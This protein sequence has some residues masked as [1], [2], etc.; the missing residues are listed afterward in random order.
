[1]QTI[2]SIFCPFLTYG[3]LCDLCMWSLCGDWNA[4]WSILTQTHAM[5]WFAINHAAVLCDMFQAS[6][7]EILTEYLLTWQNPEMR[8]RN[9]GPRRLVKLAPLLYIDPDVWKQAE[10]RLPTYHAG[11]WQHRSSCEIRCGM[12]WPWNSNIYKPGMARNCDADCCR[13]L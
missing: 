7:E 5:L 4:E 2:V 13:P 6:V 8:F 10:L 12:L 11:K 1:M 9:T 3:Y